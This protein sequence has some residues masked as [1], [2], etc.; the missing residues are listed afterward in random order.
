[1]RLLLR[2]I[3]VVPSHRM[4]I[5]CGRRRTDLLIRAICAREAIAPAPRETVTGAEEYEHAKEYEPDAD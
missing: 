2:A 1:M 4:H 5:A 3:L